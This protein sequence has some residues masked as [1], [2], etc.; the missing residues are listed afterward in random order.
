MPLR[1]W[2][3]RVNDIL[4]A[5][6][7]ISKYT[8]GMTEAQFYADEKTVDAVIRNF[9]I[10]GEA[11]NAVPAEIQSSHPGVPWSELIGMRNIVIH[12]YFKVS[13]SIVWTSLKSDLPS[14]VPLLNG[15]LSSQS[16]KP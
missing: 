11:A 16:S 15:L 6:E 13:V 4:D 10:I 3:M 7:K 8:S 5:I 12:G 2:D 1:N 14:L 9:S